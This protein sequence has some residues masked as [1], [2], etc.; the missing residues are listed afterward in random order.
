MVLGLRSM[1][2]AVALDVLARLVAPRARR[3][4]PAAP[5]GP[6]VAPL[7][8]R[9]RGWLL[10]RRRGARLALPPARKCAHARVQNLGFRS[11]G[12]TPPRAWMRSLP[13]TRG[14]VGVWVG[15][16]ERTP[17]ALG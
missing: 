16:A 8:L 11:T 12:G 7:Q 1:A 4:R 6:G 10:R 17:G 5:S 3:R 9:G 15:M 14:W 13:P 2:M